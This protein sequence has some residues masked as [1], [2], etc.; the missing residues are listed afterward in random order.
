MM[1]IIDPA[2]S[3]REAAQRIYTALGMTYER[4]DVL[5]SGDFLVW[6]ERWDGKPDPR[7]VLKNREKGK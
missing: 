2:S 4:V 7:V 3:P 6:A 5:P 1:A